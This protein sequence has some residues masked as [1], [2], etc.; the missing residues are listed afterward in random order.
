[1]IIVFSS[2]EIPSF[3][4]AESQFVVVR[5]CFSTWSI[6]FIT[7]KSLISPQEIP[8]FPLLFVIQFMINK[9]FFIFLFR[10]I[11]KY[12]FCTFSVSERIKPMYVFIF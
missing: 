5:I 11:R 3:S 6:F 10:N 12:F 7:S 9:T 2:Q 8:T 1:M 4:I